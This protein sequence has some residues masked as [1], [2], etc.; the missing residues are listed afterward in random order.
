MMI[1]KDLFEN[2]NDLIQVFNP[3]GSILFVNKGWKDTL[4]YGADENIENINF[5]DYVDKNN[6]THKYIE[7]MK[8]LLKKQQG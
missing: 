5:F 4:G 2:A 6:A 3:D 1:L 7:N 8:S